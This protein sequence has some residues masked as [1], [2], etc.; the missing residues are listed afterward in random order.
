MQHDFDLARSEIEKLRNL[1]VG[2]TLDEFGAGNYSLAFLERLSI[3]A[4][5]LAR[6]FVNRLGKSSQN[7][8]LVRAVIELAQAFGLEVG[9]VGVETETQETLLKEF[10]C[11]LVQGSYYCPPVSSNE[12]AAI[13]PVIKT[14]AD[15]ATV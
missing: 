6:P 13:G 9:A 5:K 11:Q 3:D 4:V 8:Q 2:V 14:P 12:I 15:L 7:N 1:G 10:G